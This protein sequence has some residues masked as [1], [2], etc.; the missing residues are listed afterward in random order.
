M[1]TPLAPRPL[2]AA[3]AA[4]GPATALVGPGVPGGRWSYADLADAVTAEATTYD[5]TRRLVL[6]EADRTAATVV[7]LLGAW[8][9]D[10][11]VLLTG[12]GTADQLTATYRPGIVLTADGA[13]ADR[14][15]PVPDLHPD[16]ALLLSTSGS[17]G[18]P[19]L[20]RLSADNL[21]ANARQIVD[22]LGIR[23][24]DLAATTL[25]LHYCYGLSVLTSH[26]LAG[27]G[28][29][30]TEDSVATDCFWAQATEHAIT[31]FPGVPHT[32]D[33][34]ERSGFAERDL[35]SLRYLTQAGGRMPPEQVRRFAELGQRRGFD[36]M[37]M[38]GQTEA[39]ARMAVLPADLALQRPGCVGRAV[40]GGG[41]RIAP[42]DTDETVEPG[43]GELVFSGPNVM[44]GYAHGPADLAQGRTVSELATGDLARI[45]AD[46]LVEITGRRG[47]FAKVLGLRV[48][49]DRVER[50][51]AARG[52]V[53]AAADGG[54]RLVL[55]VATGA[56][57]VEAAYV[58]ALAADELDLPPTAISVVLRP[59]LPRRESGKVD[60]AALVALARSL[61]GL[62]QRGGLDGLDQRGGLDGLD[63]RGAPEDLARIVGEALGREAGPQDSFV[64]LGGDSLT[65]VEVGLRLER[66]LG[67]LPPDWHRTTLAELADRPREERR[68]GRSVETGVVLRALAI[69]AIV[70]THAN[71]FTLLGGAHILLAV[72]GFNTARF[73]LTGAPRRERARRLL[74]AA[75][76]VAVPSAIVIGLVALWTDGLGW[77]QVAL[78]NSLTSVS[79]SE[80][81]WH[82][83]FIEVLV[84]TLAVL[85]LLLAIPALDRAERRWPFWFP[86][87]L[88]LPFLLMRYDLG[89]PPGDEVHRAPVVFF[90]FA[91]GWAASRATSH[92][93][94]LVVS[95]A[96]LVTVPGLFGYGAREVAIILGLL[97]LVWVPHLRLPGPLVRVLGVLASA[98]LWTY[99]VHW[100][101]Y[102]WFEERS[103]LLGTVLSLLAGIALWQAADRL[104]SLAV[105][106]IPA[107]RRW[108]R[109]DGPRPQAK[110]T[111]G[112]DPP[113]ARAPRRDDQPAHL[114]PGTARD[115]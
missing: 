39:T 1:Q 94:R 37:V 42:V 82:Y 81:A 104:W 105:V 99:L 35:P 83:W 65:Y 112:D 80:P 93:E 96:G 8:A 110:G 19:K 12:P 111:D 70:G 84:Q 53:V 47:R 56:R 71:L 6:L 48:D 21:R 41:F 51:L 31:T 11:V 25:P 115:R 79:W 86:L 66:A 72:A 55:G 46:G 52:L 14:E 50:L 16:L 67:T 17:T 75:A 77:R 45:G 23:P 114:A 2:P 88:G 90:L 22:A 24:T 87:V 29:L 60:T 64:S 18:S 5:A 34:L 20:V 40:P 43:V 3:L 32:F 9:A 61:D 85:A 15:E 101:V 74:T 76:R 13:R 97:A 54:D 78:V 63:Q 4:R 103:P 28:L 44:L 100:Q 33:L 38:Y 10:Q 27:A 7:R 30:L 91:L 92:R 36:L 107:A 106:G 26:L 95:I 62:D 57:P 59:D 58:V 89:D 109:S 98:S 113:R 68:W 49:L 73:Q 69:V 102:P 108:L